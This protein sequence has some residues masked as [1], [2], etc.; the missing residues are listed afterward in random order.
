LAIDKRKRVINLVLVTLI[1]M[2]AYRT[3]IIATGRPLF[4]LK[5]TLLAA[6]EKRKEKLI[7]QHRFQE[8][9]TKLKSDEWIEGFEPHVASQKER[10]IKNYVRGVYVAIDKDW[11]GPNP[12]YIEGIG[13]I[14]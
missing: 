13:Q 5:I 3:S 9:V 10:N 2:H 11:N 1:G 4:I 6:E 7:T 8:F 12:N 14:I